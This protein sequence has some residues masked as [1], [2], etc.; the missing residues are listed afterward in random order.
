M[1]QRSRELC[2][3]RAQL[4]FNN[5]CNDI[6]TQRV[7]PLYIHSET[8]STAKCLTIKRP[9][10]TWQNTIGLVC[11]RQNSVIVG[12]LAQTHSRLASSVGKGS[13][14]T[15]ERSGQA[16]GT[17]H[18]QSRLPSAAAVIQLRQLY[19]TMAIMCCHIGSPDKSSLT[20]LSPEQPW[21]PQ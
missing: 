19:R 14:L 13:T 18:C 21:P 20:T 17:A 3:H 4:K 8:C 9:H 7:R 1:M 16:L 12:E 11:Y 15:T 6:S 5:S 2:I 10:T